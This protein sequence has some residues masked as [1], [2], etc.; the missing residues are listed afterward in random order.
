MM[1]VLVLSEE[2]HQAWNVLSSCNSQ[3]SFLTVLCALIE[4]I[5]F[6]IFLQ[7]QLQPLFEMIALCTSSEKQL[8][9]AFNLFWFCCFYVSISCHFCT[10]AGSRVHHGGLETTLLWYKWGNVSK[11]CHGCLAHLAL[12]FIVEDCLGWRRNNTWLTTRPT[13]HSERLAITAAHMMTGIG[14]TGQQQWILW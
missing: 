5:T 8:H 9:K 3:V 13:Q 12:S 14:D 7:L 2:E 1:K 11:N 4:P 10:S 6:H